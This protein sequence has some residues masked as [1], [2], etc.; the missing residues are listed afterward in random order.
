MCR[1]FGV[2]RQKLTRPKKT[3][4]TERIYW[5]PFLKVRI[6]VQFQNYILIS[7]VILSFRFLFD[8]TAFERSAIKATLWS[9]Q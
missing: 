8:I 5:I 9:H 4:N 1:I 2:L 7:K 6:L 3:T